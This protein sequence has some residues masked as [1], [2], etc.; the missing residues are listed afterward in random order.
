MDNRKKTNKRKPNQMRGKQGPKDSKEKRVNYDNTREGKFE[1]D[2]EETKDGPKSNDPIWYA[3][4]AELMTAAA[5]LPYSVTTGE[6]IGII[7]HEEYIN[8][9]PGIMSLRWT[10]QIGGAFD[11]PINQAANMTYSF[12]AHAN[13]RNYKY[14]APDLMQ[15]I[16]AGSSLFAM[17]AHG[18]RAYGVMRTYDQRNMYMPRALVEAMG[19]N[20]QDLR[21]HLSQMWF[22]LNEL[23]ARSKQLWIPNHFPFTARWFW[24][25]S[26][27]YMDA[28]SVKGQMYVFVPD[29]YYIYKE[30]GDFAE[31][32]HIAENI[33]TY[34]NVE[35]FH[36]WADYVA[37]MDS[38]F[39]PLLESQDRGMI[40]GDILKA[41]GAENLYILPDITSDYRVQPVYDR[42]VLTQIENLTVWPY[43][44]ESISQDPYTGRLYTSAYTPVTEPVLYPDWQAYPPE[45]QILNF[46]VSETPTPAMNMVATRLKCAGIAGIPNGKGAAA[47]PQAGAGGVAPAACG[48]ETI[49]EVRVWYIHWNSGVPEY[50]NLIIPTLWGSGLANDTFVQEIVAWTAFDW[51]PWLYE[52]AYPSAPWT[53]KN[54]MINKSIID[55]KSGLEA[56]WHAIGDYDYYTTIDI[57]ELKKMHRTAVYSEF[58]VPTI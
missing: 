16:L 11:D 37:V 45:K 14:D 46:H 47:Y 42:E 13:S 27:I 30:T 53:D 6:K 54:T 15:I 49:K 51:A 19:F 20:Y 48:T 29:S 26:N 39:K 28:D 43:G 21:D 24:M 56:V 8:S 44:Y 34:W 40:F 55:A 1:K 9:V 52:A 17:L 33:L 57:E 7:E 18:I 10:P 5:S 25:N 4:N 41:Y 36:T 3:H 2:V 35:D 31:D 22:D 50:T 12:V 23:I 32:N 38:M 58:A